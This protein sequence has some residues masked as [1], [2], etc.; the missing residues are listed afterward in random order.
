[1]LMACLVPSG[2]KHQVRESGSFCA[3]DMFQEWASVWAYAH[4]FIPYG[5]ARNFCQPAADPRHDFPRPENFS[6]AFFW[7]FMACDHKIST[8][9]VRPK[10]GCWRAAWIN[11]ENAILPK[12]VICGGTMRFIYNACTD[13]PFNLAAEEWLLHNSETDVFMLWRNAD[14]PPKNWSA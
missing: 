8:V 1:M 7:L 5:R 10:R 2:I 11:V 14:L 3:A 6:L 13:A 4:S 12:Y 9:C